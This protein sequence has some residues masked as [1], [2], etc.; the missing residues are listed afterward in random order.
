MSD[1][2]PDGPASAQ[3]DDIVAEFI[4]AE[5]QGQRPEPRRYL[6]SFPE[7]A[8]RLRAFFANRDWFAGRASELAPTPPAR[9]H[10]TASETRLAPGSRFAGYEILGELGRGGMGVVYKA[11]HEGLNRLVALKMIRPGGDLEERARFKAEA[12]AVAR[13]QH[14]NIVQIHEVA[15]HD[16]RPFLSLEYCGGGSLSDR[17]DGTPLPP[18]EAATLIETLARAMGHAHRHGIIHRD[19]K[20]ANVLLTAAG[21]PKITDFGLARHLDSDR[22]LTQTGAVVGTP[23]YMA[24]EQAS[25]RRQDVGSAADVY[26]LGAVLYECLTGWPPFKGGTTIDTLDQVRHQE[27]VPPS[28]LQ[29]SVPRDL[30]TICLKCLRKDPGK[31]YGSAAELADDLGRFL[32]GG[33]V[34]ARPL[35]TAARLARWAGR[36][37]AVAALLVM[38]VL[39]LLLSGFVLG[40]L[41][42][43]R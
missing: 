43:G 5:E 11:R 38:L 23:S 39:A 24:P 19:L 13:L 20:P 28:R 15:E 18:A 17:L 2:A 42:F 31:R 3:F 21:V 32:R 1:T 6:E 27:P 14:P 41:P 10:A 33:P 30:E 26:A 37:P 35:G 36:R 22:G 7:L 40:W 25:G 4:R 12:E 8:D 9:P 29:G 16:G 34:L